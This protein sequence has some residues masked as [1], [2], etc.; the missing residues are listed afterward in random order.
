[1]IGSDLENPD[2]VRL[3]ESFGVP[4]FRVETPTALERELK[5]ALGRAGPTLLVVPVDKGS[6]ASP[7]DLI[8]PGGR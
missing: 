2:F 1:M 5:V 7:W 6:E 4:S 3:G 8:I